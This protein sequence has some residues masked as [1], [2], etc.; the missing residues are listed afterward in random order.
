MCI[1]FQK[2]VHDFIFQKRF[3]FFFTE[4][5]AMRATEIEAERSTLSKTIFDTLRAYE[6]Q[7]GPTEYKLIIDVASSPFAECP[8]NCENTFS[9]EWQ[10]TFDTYD[11]VMAALQ[12]HSLPMYTLKLLFDIL[13]E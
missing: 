11:E 8:N 12:K 5:M 7:F 3:Y 6:S 10:G 9:P 1:K 4:I 13:P 2:K